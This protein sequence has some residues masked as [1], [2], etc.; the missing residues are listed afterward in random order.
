MKRRVRVL[1]ALLIWSSISVGAIAF[2]PVTAMSQGTAPRPIPAE[3]RPLGVPSVGRVRVLELESK[4]MARR[5]PVQVA[6]PKSYSDPEHSGRR[7]PVAYMLHGLTGRF[8][9]WFDRT[10]IEDSNGDLII[11]TPEGENGWYTDSLHQDN[12]HY[13][14][15]IVKELIP[16]ID[17]EFRTL[18]RRQSRAIAGLSMG[19]YG[20]IKFGIKYPEMFALAGSFSGALGAASYTVESRGQLAKTI[21]EIMGPAGSE[22][23]KAN[24]VFY[25]IESATDEKLKTL[26]FIY[27][28]CGTEDFLFQTN[29]DFMDLLVKRKI[30]H[31]YRQMPGTH[32]WEYW[33]AQIQEF[34]DVSHKHLY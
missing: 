9:D 34:L 21:D 26:P 4:L 23:R 2:L 24:D 19:G 33:G 16:A 28:D 29:R 30:P 20:A 12:K 18:P 7:Y 3:L 27:F 32:N 13:E 1:V 25:L 14:S 15:Y 22:T 11:V 10:M 6:L 5:M 8:T 31:E 17:R